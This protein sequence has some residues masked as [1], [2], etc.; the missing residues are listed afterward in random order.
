MRRLML[1]IILLAVTALP[2]L[3]QESEFLCATESGFGTEIESGHFQLDLLC[4]PVLLETLE[5]ERGESITVTVLLENYY[6]AIGGDE[7]EFSIHLAMDRAR[8][9]VRAE[10]EL[11]G[12]TITDAGAALADVDVKTTEETYTFVIKN[13]GFRS[14]IFDLSVRP[15]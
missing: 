9:D 15:R 6:K 13:E 8:I 5:I 10:G 14:A 4:Q 12:T 7:A 1:A 3:A 11:G 2:T